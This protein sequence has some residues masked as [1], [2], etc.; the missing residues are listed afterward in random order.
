[1][2][3]VVGQGDFDVRD[4]RISVINYSNLKRIDWFMA[5]I[6]LALVLAGWLALYS[7]SQY[8][9]GYFSRQVVAFFVGLTIAAVII[10]IDYRFVVLFAPAMY[11]AAVT[12]LFAVLEFGHTAKGSE[13]WLQIG[14]VGVQPSELTKLVMVY[15]LAWYLSTIGDRI[16]NFFWFA[17]TFV[18]VAIPMFLILKQPNL[19]TALCMAPLCVVMLFVAGCRWRHM[20]MVILVGLSIFPFLWWQMRDFDPNAFKRDRGRTVAA[21]SSEADASAAVAGGTEDKSFL[22]HLELKPYQ[23]MR[24][25]AFL[26]PEADKGDS[27]W[28]TY[29]S[30]ITV[31]SG[32]LSGKGY[33]QGTQTKLKWLPEHHTDFIF[34]VVAEEIGFIGASVIIALFA[35]FLLRGL[36]FAGDCPDMTGTLIAVG[37]VTVLGFHIFV[38]I[39]ITLGLMPVTGIPLPFLSYGRSFYITTMMCVGVL[40]NIPMRRKLFV[41]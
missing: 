40:M 22:D 16:K 12:T 24:I 15:F 35:I 23:K 38:N 1:M 33:M 34:S 26:H 6:V 19:G 13:R 4:A 39:A 41:N 36:M 37:V 27:G 14:P 9:G 28:Q 3:I 5:L 30:L 8:S 18:L 7:A 10:V 20:A 11:L 21:A 25:Y 17:L 31:G 29:Q 32:G 2:R